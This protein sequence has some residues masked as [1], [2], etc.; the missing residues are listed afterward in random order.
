MKRHKKSCELW[1]VRKTEEK[2][3]SEFRRQKTEEKKKLEQK[4]TKEAKNKKR[5]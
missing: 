1:V 3:N 5:R 2:K 4:I